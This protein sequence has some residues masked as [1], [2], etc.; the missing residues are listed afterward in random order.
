FALLGRP[1]LGHVIAERAGHALHFAMTQKIM[2]DP[3][4][5]ELLT[6]DE[7]ASDVAEALVGASRID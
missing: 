4:L 3:S 2:S 1:L 6:F 5:Y 7:L